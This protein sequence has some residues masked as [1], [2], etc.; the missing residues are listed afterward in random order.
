MQWDRN[1]KG[2]G[3]FGA[4]R[5]SI[6]QKLLASTMCSA[7]IKVLGIQQ[8]TNE[9]KFLPNQCLNCSEGRQI[10]INK[11]M[12]SIYGISNNQEWIQVLWSYTKLEYSL[13]Q[14]NPDIIHEHRKFWCW[15]FMSFIVN[16]L[17]YL[18]VNFSRRRTGTDKWWMWKII[19]GNTGSGWGRETEE[20]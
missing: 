6:P 3:S 10:I 2:F 8:W 17:K 9:L 12:N 20:N 1:R 15:C 14:K 18:C 4:Y 7:L 19:P 5:F 16:L 13:L 11:Q